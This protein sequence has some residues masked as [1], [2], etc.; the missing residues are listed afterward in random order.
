MGEEEE[1]KEEVKESDRASV[2]RTSRECALCIS[3]GK[4]VENKTLFLQGFNARRVN[5]KKVQVIHLS[6]LLFFIFLFCE[7]AQTLPKVFSLA[8]TTGL[9]CDRINTLPKK[10]TLAQFKICQS[11]ML[12]QNCLRKRNA[13]I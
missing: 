8:N 7:D 9:P 11:C 2:M 13:H 1:E 6:T 10:K 4:S 12:R 3:P 5:Y